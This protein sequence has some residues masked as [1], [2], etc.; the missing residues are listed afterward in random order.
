MVMVQGD[1]PLREVQVVSGIFNLNRELDDGRTLNE[2]LAWLEGTLKEFPETVVFT[3]FEIPQQM[4]ESFKNCLFV[5]TSLQS[6]NLYGSK[7]KINNICLEKFKLKNSDLVYRNSD[8]GILINSKIELLARAQILRPAKSFL[9]LDAGA[10]RF[11]ASSFQP[12][13]KY[14]AKSKSPLLLFDI[15]NYFRKIISSRSL[16]PKKIAPFGSSERIVG[17]ITIFIPSRFLQTLT[18]SYYDF[19]LKNLVG[20]YWDTEQVF[21]FHFLKQSNFKLV[22]QKVGYFAMFESRGKFESLIAKLLI[23]VTTKT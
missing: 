21:L 6:L 5:S 10:S 15:R 2:Y 18:Q 12:S 7:D 8:Y 4:I 16:K 22:I 23:M 14:L 17:A 13:M 11:F 19:V 9:W 20:G 1:F 3:N